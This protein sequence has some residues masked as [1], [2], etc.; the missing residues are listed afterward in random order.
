MA[1]PQSEP[2][3]V[4]DVEGQCTMNINTVEIPPSILT[5]GQAKEFRKLHIHT[6]TRY[7]PFCFSSRSAVVLRPWDINAD[8]SSYTC[9]EPIALRSIW[10]TRRLLCSPPGTKHVGQGTRASFPRTRDVNHLGN[11][12]EIGVYS[13]LDDVLLLKVHCGNGYSDDC[14]TRDLVTTE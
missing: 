7:K 11:K 4:Q 1:T 13:V 5:A 9:R 3:G 2:Q 12:D 6:Q 14:S 8:A 10:M